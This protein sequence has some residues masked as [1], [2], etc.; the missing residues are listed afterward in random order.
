MNVEYY[1]KVGAVI[2]GSSR[3]QVVMASVSERFA[4]KNGDAAGPASDEAVA[5]AFFD[6][7][8]ALAHLKV[9]YFGISNAVRALSNASADIEKA[10]AAA[11]EKLLAETRR[12]HSAVAHML[13]GLGFL[14]FS[15]ALL[16]A[17]GE[18]MPGAPGFGGA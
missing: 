7:N 4:A 16:R 1:E 3:L 14:E 17:K 6:R 15:P 9:E 8:P 12:L 18:S 13:E 5:N 2:F 11:I 10:D